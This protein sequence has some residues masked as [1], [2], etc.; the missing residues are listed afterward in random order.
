MSYWCLAPFATQVMLEM[1]ADLGASLVLFLKSKK[2]L[3]KNSSF[4]K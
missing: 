1:V 2:K 4:T 3:E